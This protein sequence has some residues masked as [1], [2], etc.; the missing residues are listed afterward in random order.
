LSEFTTQHML[1]ARATIYIYRFRPQRHLILMPNLHVCWN[2]LRITLFYSNH[3]KVLPLGVIYRVASTEPN[4][5][6]PAQHYV[7]ND[8]PFQNLV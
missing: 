4:Q 8:G 6:T 3:P 7:Q 2:D 5:I 1:S